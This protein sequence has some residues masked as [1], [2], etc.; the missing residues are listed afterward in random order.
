MAITG[1][2]VSSSYLLDHVAP[3]ANTDRARLGLVTQT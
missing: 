3:F 2:E 1:R